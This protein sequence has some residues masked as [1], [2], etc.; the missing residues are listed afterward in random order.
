MYRERPGDLGALGLHVDPRK[1]VAALSGGQ[2]QLIA[3]A[4][5]ITWGATS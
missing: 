2:R 3:V 4:R 5:A 1:P